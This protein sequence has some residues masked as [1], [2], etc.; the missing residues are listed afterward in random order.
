MEV[1]HKR[2]ICD[3]AEKKSKYL[4]SLPRV[5][6]SD[7]EESLNTGNLDKDETAYIVQNFSHS[8]EFRRDIRIH[9]IEECSKINYLRARVKTA[10]SQ[11]E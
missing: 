3:F 1:G 9:L 5:E 7:L 11:S 2:Q 10:L 8:D 6:D 4:S